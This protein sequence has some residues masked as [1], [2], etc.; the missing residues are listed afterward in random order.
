M[1]QF[2]GFT[3]ET[4]QF[5]SAL[6]ENNNRRWFEK[7]KPVFRNVVQHKAQDFVT[8]M[9]DGLK[10]ISPELGG[11]VRL[12]GSG[13]IFRIYRDVRFSKDKTPYK[14]HLGILFWDK[15]KKKMESPGFYLHLEPLH[16]S[17]YCGVY[18]IPK[19]KLSNYRDG[20]ADDKLGHE[21]VEIVAKAKREGFI[22]GESY[23]K[24]YPAGV[25]INEDRKPFLLYNSLYFKYG[26]PIP[27]ELFSTELVDY[28]L[29]IWKEMA[30]VYFWLQKVF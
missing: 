7:N 27:D 29:K 12:N 24:R 21:L 6:K 18:Q 13:S 14:T 16:L 26:T 23:Y 2:D 19:D 9:D 11:D 20:V 1:S 15:R 4:L 28:T 3:Q 5:L 17:L 8:T 22:V 30:P 10:V 25:D